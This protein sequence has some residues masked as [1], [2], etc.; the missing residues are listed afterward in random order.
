MNWKQLLNHPSIAT[1]DFVYLRNAECYRG[2]I[3]SLRLDDL[4][5]NIIVVTEWVAKHNPVNMRWVRWMP[6]GNDCLEVEINTKEVSLKDPNGTFIRAVKDDATFGYF[7]P[8]S[9]S[10]LDFDKLL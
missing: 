7:I 2:P 1:M 9:Y 3:K 6:A 5:E 8:H 4:R 10:K